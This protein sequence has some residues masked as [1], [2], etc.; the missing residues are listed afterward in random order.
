M[1][2]NY[3]KIALRNL[4]KNKTYSFLN[5]FGLAVGLVCAGVIFLWVE[6]EVTFDHIH[7]K[8][9]RIYQVM[10][11]WNYDGSIRTFSSC[12]APMAEAM[13]RELPGIRQ[14]CRTTEGP[15]NA[16]FG[17]GEKATYAN[18]MYAD[19]SLFGIFTLPF[20]EGNAATAFSQ[21]YSLVITEKT[22]QKL[23][24]ATRNIVGKTIIVDNK[25]PYVVSGVVKDNPGNSSIQFDWVAPFEIYYRANKYLS[26]WDANSVSI[27]AELAPNANFDIINNLLKNAIRQ[28]DPHAINQAFLLSM[29]DWRLHS[30]FIDGKQSGGRIE[31]VRLFSLIAW[32]ILVI[33]C[34]NFMNLSTARSEKRAKEVGVRKTMGA[35]KNRLVLQFIG[36]A[37][38]FAILS[39][40]IAVLL[41]YICLP[42][43]NKMV[44]KQLTVDLL[45]PTHVLFLLILTVTCG[46]LAGSYPSLYL[47]SFNPVLVLK[48]FKSAPGGGTFI[49][50][51][52]VITQF[53]ISIVLIICTIIIFQQIQHV[54]HRNLGLN[55]E[56]LIV[57]NNTGEMNTHY[58]FIKTALLATGAVDQ[59]ALADHQA[60]YGGNNTNSL[61]WTGKRP[62][63]KILVSQRLISPGFFSTLG[64]KFIAG[65]DFKPIAAAN[66]NDVIVTASMEKLMGPGSA[67]GKMIMTPLRRDS[68]IKSRVAGV[69]EDYVYGNMYGTPDPVVF[70]C[71]PEEATLTYVRMA[72]GI[73]K[74]A[75]LEKI[76]RVMKQYNP[77]YPFSYRFVDD[78]FN[79]MFVNEMLMQQLSRLFAAL[80]ILISCLGLFGL[81]AYTAERRTKEISIRKILGAS[82]TNITQLLS[83]D[84]LKLVA[85][86]AIIAFPVAWFT[87][88]NW[89]QKYPYRVNIHY[90]VFVLAGIIAMIIALFTVSFQSIKAAMGNPAENLKE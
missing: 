11:H 55:K 69:V 61:D 25:Q 77:A 34:I 75:A 18:G 9:D 85:I 53:S 68:V 45:A 12:P 20:V 58:E 65:S 24:G 2:K 5:I 6:D 30:Q 89:L 44:D 56:N 64:M 47:S 48:G 36:E 19:P 57:M 13:K 81:A 78:Q 87:M 54:K 32:I 38:F 72:S 60:I 67:V 10:E 1:F 86:S 73:D 14:T 7:Q 29:N 35:S 63:D 70:Y 16:M 17:T 90:W 41:L 23:F 82:T 40:V 51:G 84:F 83:A 66:G 88:S 79:A 52:L 74:E 43:F 76:G 50:K 33:A 80:A 49:R 3:L 37:L 46:L 8:K 31:Y 39:A 62:T 27:Y 21:L 26:E 4:W 71:I 42:A 28:R 22:A 15:I 59:V